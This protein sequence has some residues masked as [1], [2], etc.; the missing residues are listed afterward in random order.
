M[1]WKIILVNGGIVLILSL[2]TFF[3]LR[4]S[5]Q[6]AVADPKL[7]RAELARALGAAEA[8]LTLD[9]L[10]AER[11][12]DRQAA[13]DEVRGLFE[14]GTADARADAATA[15]ANQLRDLA[16]ASGEFTKMAPSLVLFVDADGVGMGRNGSELMRGDRVAA[17]Y[18]EL[19]GSLTSGNTGSALWV[20]ERRQEQLLASYAPVRNKEGDLVGA[21]IVGTALNDERLSLLVDSATSNRIALLV[22]N[23]SIA[24]GGGRSS[25]FQDASVVAAATRAKVGKVSQVPSA[26]EGL[27]LGTMGM[28]SF[29]GAVL[30]GAVPVSLVSSIDALLWPVFSVALL[31]LF[32][33][34]T[35]GFL[36]GNYISRPIAEIEEGL[37][38]VINGQQDLR[39]DLE[40]DELGGLTSRINSLLNSLLGV[41]EGEEQS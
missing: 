5:L 24:I 20:D 14:A 4:T 25:A 18:P 15:V 41:N 36:L 12:L 13:R 21:V 27:F 3:L 17:A 38:L 37:L 19:K 30:V 23:R 6:Q 32:L 16:V 2:I 31:G 8:R 22:N 26:R 11:W 10:L 9:A 34:V 40:H 28:S 7:Q 1:R 29:S 35:G 33:V 39:F